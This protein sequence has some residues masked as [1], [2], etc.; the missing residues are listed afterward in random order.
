MI[1]KLQ[2]EWEHKNE[3][4]HRVRSLSPF[5]SVCD[6]LRESEIKKGGETEGGR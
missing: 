1:D 2:K 3:N 6:S 5:K 4:K